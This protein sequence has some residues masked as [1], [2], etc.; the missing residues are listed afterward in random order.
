MNLDV[1][2]TAKQLFNTTWDLFD[3]GG[4]RTTDDDIDMLHKAHTSRYLWGLCGDPV[5]FARGEWQIS[6]A[7]AL[8]KMGEPALL[9]GQKSLQ[10]AVDN[11]LDALDMAFGHECV[12][13]AFAVLGDYKNAQLHKDKGLEIAAT[14]VKDREY[15]ENE[16]NSIIF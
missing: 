1:I 3:K 5:N 13:R 16:I 8:L 15:A 10:I 11:D 2:N 9:H 7:Y 6:R 4:E 12:A 14:M